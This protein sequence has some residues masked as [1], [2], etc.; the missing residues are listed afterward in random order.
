[1]NS[2]NGTVNIAVH[3]D[4]RNRAEIIGREKI[5]SKTIELN[6]SNGVLPKDLNAWFGIYKNGVFTRYRVNVSDI[7]I[8]KWIVPKRG[9]QILVLDAMHPSLARFYPFVQ[10][11]NEGLP[12]R[13]FFLSSHTHIQLTHTPNNR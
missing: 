1:M 11:E 2:G 8:G 4:V 3:V 10:D 13:F 12:V 9:Q 5:D 7:L 6:S